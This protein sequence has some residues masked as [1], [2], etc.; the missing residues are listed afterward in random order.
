MKR[1]LHRGSFLITS[2]DP[3]PSERLWRVVFDHKRANDPPSKRQRLLPASD[4][5]VR[6]LR[7]SAN[8]ALHWAMT[9]WI[10]LR[11]AEP[12]WRAAVLDERASRHAFRLRARKEGSG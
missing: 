2:A 8:R 5:V 11:R 12:G 7:A 9:P 6:R 4:D 3:T 10:A 1:G